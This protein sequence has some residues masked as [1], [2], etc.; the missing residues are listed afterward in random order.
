MIASGEI[1]RGPRIR[2]SALAERFASSV[3]PVREA[4]RQLQA[5]G[6]RTAS[7]TAPRASPRPISSRSKA[8]TS[9]AA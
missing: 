1:A 9:R 4:L 3:T 5:E 6:G 8:P 2:Q 7:R